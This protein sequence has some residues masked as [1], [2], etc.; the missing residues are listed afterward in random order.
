[1]TEDQTTYTKQD[2][3]R[4]INA[5]GTSLVLKKDKISMETEIQKKQQQIEYKKEYF[6]RVQKKTAELDAVL[7]GMES[8]SIE[9]KAQI[10]GFKAEK[11]AAIRQLE[12]ILDLEK[13]AAVLQQRNAEIDM[14]SDRVKALELKT[15]RLSPEYEDKLREKDKLDRELKQAEDAFRS[16][17]AE[18]ELL[19][20]RRQHLF[21]IIPSRDK[22]SDAQHKA[23]LSI[24]ENT[25]LISQAKGQLNALE[26]ELPPLQ[27]TA[28]SLRQKRQPLTEKR[29]D[30]QGKISE[31]TSVESIEDLQAE[32]AGLTVKKDKLTSTV[33]ANNEKISGLTKEVEAAEN[34]VKEEEEFTANFAKLNIDIEAAK[35]ELSDIENQLQ[36]MIM[37]EEANEKLIEVLGPIND[38]MASINGILAKLSQEYKTAVEKVVLAIVQEVQ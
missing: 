24:I 27:A 3:V 2:M 33:D 32:I 11:D 19:I 4:L 21:T 16:L 23:E 8:R 15:S 37:D 20:N 9:I 31:I 13:K 7:R 12:Q 22:L 25:A 28:A 34:S 5:L 1:M 35:A 10:D 26:T 6:E 30:L 38:Y 29:D 14:L 17:N 18:Y 36:G